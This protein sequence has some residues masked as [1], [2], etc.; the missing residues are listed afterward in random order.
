MERTFF[1]TGHAS[2]NCCTHKIFIQT[3]TLAHFSKLAH[4]RTW[5]SKISSSKSPPPR[6]KAYVWPH[7]THL[8]RS[9]AAGIS[10]AR[11][12]LLMLQCEVPND[13]QFSG[14]SQGDDFY[15]H[16]YQS[17]SESYWQKFP[18][19][20]LSQPH[21]VFWDENLSM[22]AKNGLC[23]CLHRRAAEAL[24]TGVILLHSMQDKYGE[25]YLGSWMF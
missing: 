14:K 23:V 18:A 11:N 2:R 4:R 9:S 20:D 25:K 17:S 19:L 1:I 12:S 15:S 5:L 24:S 3:T 6:L 8:G 16:D 7:P 22:R 21:I 10:P 13:K